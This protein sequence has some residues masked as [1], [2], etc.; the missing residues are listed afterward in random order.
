MLDGQWK[1][2]VEPV[3]K[4]E[5]RSCVIV[6]RPLGYEV[7]HGLGCDGIIISH[8]FDHRI[9]LFSVLKKINIYQLKLFS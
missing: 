7:P 6:I 2:D 5:I 8:R 3:K 9:I 1:S 4:N